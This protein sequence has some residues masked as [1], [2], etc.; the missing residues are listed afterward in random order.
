MQGI[1]RRLVVFRLHYG[2]YALPLEHMVEIVRMVA[3]SPVPDA[4]TWLLGVINLRGEV[5]PVLD[6]RLRLGLPA[7]EIELNTPILIGRANGRVLGLVA[8]E[9]IEVLTAD[10]A[11][12]EPP[13]EMAGPSTSLTGVVRREDRLV[14]IL[15]L[16]RLLSGYEPDLHT[17]DADDAP[18]RVA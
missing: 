3:V 4:P 10:P 15:D 18:A 16:E 7:A 2:E 14:M 13:E 9:V 8:D 1:E 11:S 12:I 5:V 6:L 17:D